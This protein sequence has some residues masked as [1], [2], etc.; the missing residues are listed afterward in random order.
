LE[1]FK[2]FLFGRKQRV[3]VVGSFSQ[4]T[5]VLSGILQGSVFGPV[6]FICYIN[7]LPE[8][9]SSFIFLYAEV[10]RRVECDVDKEA[11]QRDLDQLGKEMA[12]KIQYRKM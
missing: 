12:A 6:M 3:V 4:W 9:I 10:F 2:D 1:R 11:L 8:D 7:D 5:H